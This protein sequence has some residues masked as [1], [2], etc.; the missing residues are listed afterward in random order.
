MDRYVVVIDH[1]PRELELTVA[2][3]R[4]AGLKVEGF[5]S[6]KT[7]LDFAGRSTTAAI[8]TEVFMPDMDGIEVLRFIQ[9]ELPR[10]GVIAVGG[11]P[12]GLGSN[13]LT[14]MNALGAAEILSK[15]VDPRTLVAAVTRVLRQQD[16]QPASRGDA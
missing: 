6:A 7:A 3:L 15:P 2:L 5:A 14:A 16:S 9:R 13:Y 11:T 1:N 8:V 12:E 4:L 10:I